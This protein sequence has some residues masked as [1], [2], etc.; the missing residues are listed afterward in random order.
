MTVTDERRAG[1]GTAIRQ[2]SVE[3]RTFKPVKILAAIG[4]FALLMEA[5]IIGRWV[6]GPNFKETPIGPSEVPTYMKVGLTGLTIIGLV[7]WAVCIWYFLINPWRKERRITVDG[8]F[9]ITFVLIYWLDPFGDWIVPQFTYN[10]WLWNRGSWLEESGSLM[11]N[12][13]NIPEPVFLTGPLYLWCIFGVVVGANILMRKAKA[14]WPQLG[15]F[16]M[17]TGTVLC[18]IVWDLFWELT[19]IRIGYWTYPTTPSWLTVFGGSWYRIHLTEPICW[20]TTWAAFALLRYYKDDKGR[21]IA[22][23]GIDQVRTTARNKSFLRFAAI[24]G[25]CNVFF[26]LFYIIP[27][28]AIAIHGDSWPKDTLKRSYF[29][30]YL[31]G[32][33]TDYACPSQGAPIPRPKSAHLNPAGT[34]VPGEVPNSP[35]PPVEFQTK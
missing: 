4:V 8:M 3:Q 5:W 6:T 31:C 19:F 26:L 11:P 28:N 14:R 24:Y 34:L 20:G 33:G 13:G 1:G 23:R 18:F 7:A 9:S 25:T 15:T 30:N 17:V 29:T 2:T 10:S 21:T 16:G 22:E 27:T 12:A 35:L 32:D